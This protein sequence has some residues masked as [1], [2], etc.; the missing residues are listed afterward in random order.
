M[1]CPSLYRLLRIVVLLRR[2]EL[3]FYAGQFLGGRSGATAEDNPNIRSSHH[4]HD[5]AKEH[6]PPFGNS[7]PPGNQG[8]DNRGEPYYGWIYGAVAASATAVFRGGGLFT[9]VGRS[10]RDR[11]LDL[12]LNDSLPSTAEPENF[13]SLPAAE[14]YLYLGIAGPGE[15]ERSHAMGLHFLAVGSVLHLLE[16]MTSPAHVRN[17]FLADHVLPVLIP[18]AFTGVALES[19]GDTERFGRFL[20][21]AFGGG[22]DLS[23]SLPFAAL[24][25]GLRSSYAA[26]IPLLDASGLDAVDFWEVLTARVNAHFFSRAT[27]D[28]RPFVD[29]K[30]NPP[31]YWSPAVP[32]CAIEGETDETANGGPAS[33]VR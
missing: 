12:P 27:V 6:G 25:V 19:A 29:G 23:P 17:D 31:G 9:L 21:L 30:V 13:L 1:I 3:R 18:E 26:Q 14:K 10:A 32:P 2:G 20:A 4:F 24:P 7:A 8:L 22:A 5:P 15:D 11:A 16:D 28:D 33:R